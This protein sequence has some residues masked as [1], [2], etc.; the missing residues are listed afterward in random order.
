MAVL[1]AQ[2]KGATDAERA[3]NLAESLAGAKSD[4]VPEAIA[5]LKTAMYELADK[6]GASGADVAALEQVAGWLATL[7]ISDM[8]GIST[9]PVKP[10]AAA[11]FRVPLVGDV[12]DADAR[13]YLSLT[14][15]VF[16]AAVRQPVLS[17]SCR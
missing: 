14:I 5:S 15:E 4:A 13:A 8:P 9:A 12:E 10:D 3:H 16:H 1:A 6:S 7:A 17:L 2:S 11:E